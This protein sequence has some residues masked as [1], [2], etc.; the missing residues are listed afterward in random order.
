MGQ[1]KEQEI[2]QYDLSGD[3]VQAAVV[4]LSFSR[5]ANQERAVGHVSC[6]LAASLWVTPG[7]DEWRVSGGGQQ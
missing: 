3:P 5:L 6:H 1:R 7:G 4:E 2:C